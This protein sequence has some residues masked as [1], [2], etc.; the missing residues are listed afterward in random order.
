MSS[1]PRSCCFRFFKYLTIVGLLIALCCAGYAVPT[2]LDSL[3]TLENQS[4]VSSQFATIGRNIVFSCAGILGILVAIGLISV[5][6]ESYAVCLLIGILLSLFTICLA[7][8]M[9]A[10]VFLVSTDLVFNPILVGANMIATVFLLI[11]TGSLRS[12]AEVSDEDDRSEE[13]PVMP[14]K[15]PPRMDS[16]DNDSLIDI[17]RPFNPVPPVQPQL[18]MMAMSP[19]M[20]A[21]VEEDD[22][23]RILIENEQLEVE[24]MEPEVVADHQSMP[25]M[26][27]QAAEIWE[28][29][30]REH[31]DFPEGQQD[32]VTVDLATENGV[33][34][35]DLPVKHSDD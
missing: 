7:M 31:A 14:F 13:T 30:S 28:E 24:S 22:D 18:P 29:S 19:E 32:G 26:D 33:A 25:E 20:V 16:D 11:F 9:I 2:N 10:I 23:E 27:D 3:T 1:Q 4:K 12:P 21:A 8:G 17:N 34:K 6:T 15:M 35:D 5:S